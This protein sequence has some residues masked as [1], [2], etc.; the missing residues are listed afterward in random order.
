MWIWRANVAQRYKF[1]LKL[2]EAAFVEVVTNGETLNQIKLMNF[3]SI[4]LI[5]F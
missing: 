1:T 4:T 3:T 5:N 2:S